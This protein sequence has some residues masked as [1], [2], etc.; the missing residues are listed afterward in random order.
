MDP[1]RNPFAPGAGSQPPEL[2]G[3]EEI[4]SAADTALQRILLGRPAQS[5]MLLGLR[6]VGKTVLLNKIEQIAE[7]HGY[8]SSFIEAPEDRKLVELLYPKIQQVIRKLSL[9]DAA[10]ATAHAAMRALRSFASAFKISVGDFE[11][12]VDPEPGVA[13]S[14]NLEYDITELFLKIGEAAKAAG[15]GWV[16]LIDEVQYLSAEELGALIVAIH[17]INQKALPVIF[18]GAGL[19]A[20]AALSGDAKSYAERLFIFPKVDALAEADASNAI[21]QPIEE[22]GETISAD[23]LQKIVSLTRGYPYFCRSGGISC[24]MR[25]NNLRSALSA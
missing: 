2:A 17:R 12:S 19:P 6:G 13:D 18:F 7:E 11:L 16:L 15:R 1:A 20:I 21:R 23:L 24:G 14:G 10:K 25:P 3:R 8:L 22:E 9:V 5:Q 4:I